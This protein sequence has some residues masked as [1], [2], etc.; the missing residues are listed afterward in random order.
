[1]K[2]DTKWNMKVNNYSGCISVPSQN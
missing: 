1:M 2:L